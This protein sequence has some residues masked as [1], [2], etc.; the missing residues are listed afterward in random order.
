MSTQCVFPNAVIPQQAWSEPARHLL[1]YVPLPNI[2]DSTFSTG[3]QGKKLLDDKMSFRLD[4]D[5]RHCGLLSAYYF[6]D[7]YDLNNPYPTGQGGASVPGFIAQN[8][9][10][11]QLI[12]LGQTKTLGAF[13]VN[14]LRLSY[15]RSANEVG[16]PVGGVGVTLTSQGFVTGAGTP[17][18]VPL[19][20]GSEGVGNIIFRSFAK[21]TTIT[22]MR[23]PKKTFAAI[24][25]F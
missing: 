5:S 9:G 23:K 6:F 22:G 4:L 24:E 3:S 2:G 20:P 18:R 7:A 25:I 12:S 11:E 19:S 21:G 13:A 8:L 16:R 17:G 15:M 14:E 10:R 1:R